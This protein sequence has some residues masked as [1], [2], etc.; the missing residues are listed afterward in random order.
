MSWFLLVVVALPVLTIAWWLWA[1]AR[2]RRA[3]RA[4]TRRLLLAGFALAMLGLYAW[5]MF[6]RRQNWP[7]PPTPVLTFTYVW[8]LVALPLV[9]LAMA[10]LLGL[11]LAQRAAGRLRR[12]SDPHDA[13]RPP[14]APETVRPA[15]AAPLSRRAFL[16][17]ASAA[18][19]PLLAGAGS[20]RGLAQLDEFRVRELEVPLAALPAALDGLTIAHVS[21]MHVG[22]FTRGAVLRRI[23]EATN[24][25]R[26]DLVLVTG[27]LIDFDLDDLPAA[28]DLLRRID[29]RGGMF[30][31][32]GNH[33][34][35]ESRA[36]FERGVR[37]AGLRLL[38]N[39]AETIAVRGAAVQ[40]LGLRWGR[41]GGGRG[42]LVEDQF[43][44]LQPQRDAG[45][46]QILLAHHP[47][48]FDAAAG[49]GVPLT[50][51]GHTHGGQLNLT[52]RIGLGPLMFRYWSGLYRKNDAALVVS[53]G[54][55]NWFPLRTAAPAE[56]VRVTLR[57]SGEA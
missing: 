26:A 53:N 38:L 17:S 56:I 4:R 13:P 37:A 6:G 12:S 47:H 1:D 52:E 27:D 10:G 30:V 28:A 39:E 46:F 51:A 25:L 31:V 55:G 5:L 8:Y 57:A 15:D 33:D 7:L 32:E 40:I 54:V 24:E 50:L 2:L 29:P 41:P 43:A 14:A 35:F 11:R 19:A 23:A 49:A 21:D 44:E 36:G 20:A 3:G 22:K 9:T 45:A 16:A 18:A 48:A 42:A 34:L